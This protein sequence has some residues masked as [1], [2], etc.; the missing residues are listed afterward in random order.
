MAIWHDLLWIP[1]RM[2]PRSNFFR[3]SRVFIFCWVCSYFLCVNIFYVCSYFLCVF[4]FFMCVHIFCVC[5]YFLCVF[6]FFVC[7]YFLC[8]FIFFMCDYILCVSTSVDNFACL[9]LCECV[10]VFLVRAD[11]YLIVYLVIL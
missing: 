9:I 11:G 5:S 10:L 2:R 4:I 7:L 3:E 6:I 1:P 8:V